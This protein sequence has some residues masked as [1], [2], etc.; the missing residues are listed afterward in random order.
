MRSSN[1][2]VWIFGS[3]FVLLLALSIT[4]LT[5]E[6]TGKIHGDPNMLGFLLPLLASAV[7]AVCWMIANHPAR[8][9]AN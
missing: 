8:V 5:L 4:M 7:S 2:W 6:L 1:K 9:L 3:A